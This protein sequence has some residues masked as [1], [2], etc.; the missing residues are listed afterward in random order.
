MTVPD[1]D[2]LMDRLRR[3]GRS[4]VPDMQVG[5][6]RSV[7]RLISAEAELA[8]LITDSALASGATRS[9]TEVRTVEFAISGH[10][11]VVR[12]D[13]ERGEIALAP[14]VPDAVVIETPMDDIDA[15]LDAVG[16]AA[17]DVPVGWWRLRVDVDG[18]SIVT[19]WWRGDQLQ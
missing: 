12:L 14:G 5:F 7:H 17:F 1:D 10:A 9:S 2:E 19:P 4:E 18:S 11:L 6:A 15:G 8:E 16:G 13:G 3:A